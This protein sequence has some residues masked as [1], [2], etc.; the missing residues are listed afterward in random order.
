VQGLQAIQY[1]EM[2]GPV[3][4]FTAPTLD[5]IRKFHRPAAA[6]FF[7]LSPRGRVS[8]PG[9]L[10]VEPIA[11]TAAE[12]RGYNRAVARVGMTGLGR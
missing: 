10:F 2:E 1:H 4:R 8:P 7:K 3:G 11:H 6:F 5:A 12:C 9:D